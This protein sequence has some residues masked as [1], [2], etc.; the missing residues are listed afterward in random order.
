MAA[1]TRK[2]TT[3]NTKKAQTE[4]AQIEATTFDNEPE[5]ETPEGETISV[6]CCLPL[7]LK[8][9][10][11]P[12]GK[13]GTK[14]IILP[15]VNSV[16]RGKKTGILLGAGN[17][18]CVTLAKSDWEALLAIHGR[19]DAFVG[20][21]GQMPCIYP[22]GDVKGF[23]AARDEIKEMK[24]GLEPIEPKAVGVKEADRQELM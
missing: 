20:R 3:R 9:T 21:N 6:A 17:A 10:D 14:T 18:V 16:L 2:K 7:G 8:F 15:G 1:T 11:I 4:V 13:G 22:V 19:E 24:T 23:K 5:I 12:N